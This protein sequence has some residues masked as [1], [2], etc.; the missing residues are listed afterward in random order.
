MNEFEHI[1]NELAATAAGLRWLCRDLT[2]AQA[3]SRIDEYSWSFHQ[4][5]IHLWDYELEIQKRFKMLLEQELPRY[6]DWDEKER[7]SLFDRKSLPVSKLLNE[8]EER[9]DLTLQYIDELG[10]DGIQK[11]VIDNRGSEVTGLVIARRVAYHD[12]NHMGTMIKIL[13]KGV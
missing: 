7:M 4:L 12:R 11:R 3:R 6:D 10:E 2:D 5:L 1:R 13:A 8:F 9:R